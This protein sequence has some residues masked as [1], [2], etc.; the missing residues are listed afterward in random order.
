MAL[1]LD[2]LRTIKDLSRRVASLETTPQPPNIR[3]AGTASAT[4]SI[5]ANGTAGDV[6]LITI[7]LLDNQGG[8]LMAT[9]HFA[10]YKNNS[11]TSANLYP[12]GSNWTAD[13]QLG[14]RITSWLDLH[15]T[16]NENVVFKVML[17]NKY[18]S[19]FSDL[20]LRINH[21]YLTREVTTS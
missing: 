11:A 13:E 15:E 21:R 9:P 4:F 5:A 20:L 7:T 16:D 6:V 8:R 14:L 2:I 19:G 1:P 17:A 18:S 12:F 10:I 3:L